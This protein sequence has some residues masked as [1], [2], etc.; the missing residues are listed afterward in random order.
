MAPTAAARISSIKSPPGSH[1]HLMRLL[2]SAEISILDSPALSVYSQPPS[3]DPVSCIFPPGAVF[4]PA[5]R[6]CCPAG[7]IQSREIL[8]FQRIPQT[9]RRPSPPGRLISLDPP[10]PATQS[11]PARRRSFLPSLD[12]KKAGEGRV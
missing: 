9:P 12:G 5:R 2:L 1:S 3:F 8:S 11:P 7:K 4:A 6:S 10:P